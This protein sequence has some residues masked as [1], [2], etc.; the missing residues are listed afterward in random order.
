MEDFMRG[1][2]L[3]ALMTTAATH[4]VVILV[5]NDE[6]CQAL[7]IRSM[8]TPLTSIG[9]A[10]IHTSN[11]QVMIKK[12]IRSDALHDFPPDDDYASRAMRVEQRRELLATLWH[13]LSS[14]S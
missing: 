2:T 5:A 10:G 9:L 6:E 13:K 4:S 7:I 11:L 12:A 8:N 14:P 3:Q 1:P